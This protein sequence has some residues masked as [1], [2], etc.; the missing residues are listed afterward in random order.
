MIP[1]AEPGNWTRR[2]S[3]AMQGRLPPLWVQGSP[4]YGTPVQPALSCFFRQW[5]V[6]LF[7]IWQA[8]LS[9]QLTFLNHMVSSFYL[10]RIY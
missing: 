5:V 6:K 10:R 2:M 4:Q 8:K 7:D 9:R 3:L 1:V